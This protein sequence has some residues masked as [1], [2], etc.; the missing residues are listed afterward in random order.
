MD[1]GQEL[2]QETKRKLLAKF[3]RFGSYFAKAAIEYNRNLL[4]HTAETDGKNIFVDPDYFESLNEN[5]RM[6][7]IA[8]EIMHMRFEHMY[9]LKDKQTGKERDMYM[10]NIATDAII[11]ANLERD[12][13][14]AKDEYV[15]IEG[16]LNYTAEKLYDKLM[17]EKQEKQQNQQEEQ[18]QQNQQEEQSQQNQQGE[19]S[20]QNQKEGQGQQNQQGEQGQQSEYGELVDSHEIW[21]KAFEDKQEEMSEGNQQQEPEENDEKEEF[22]A[23]RKQKRDKFRARQ[24]E[25][26]AK[27]TLPQTRRISGKIGESKKPI[28]WRILLKREMESNEQE[29]SRRRAIKENQYASRLE[30]VSQ[31]EAVTEVIMDTSASVDEEMLIGF[32]RQLKP[33]LYESK[34]KVGCFDTEFYGFSEIKTVRDIEQL[35]IQGGGAT[36]LDVAARAFTKKR[37]VNKIIFTDGYGRMPKEDLKKEN[38]VWLVYDNSDF[39]PC[40]GKVIEITSEQLE[41]MK[42]TEEISR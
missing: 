40:C 35:K 19:Q 22:E 18:E 1:K 10:W 17:K 26:Q 37:E 36:D 24:R 20:Q 15:K 14:K 9:R 38:I 30:D 8:H 23:N 32:L 41:Q 34:L 12:G 33:L 5:D 2:I 29:W 42:H 7:L 6:F 4:Y 28:D 13:L 11:N 39:T 25:S 21:E 3:P 16:A 27:K 31:D